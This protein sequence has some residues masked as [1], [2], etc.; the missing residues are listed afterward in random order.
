MNKDLA[1]RYIDIAS[2][3][4]R[5]KYISTGIGQESTYL[6][7]SMQAREY[8]ASGYT[9]TIP[10]FV[11]VEMDVTGMTNIQAT[12][13]ILQTEQQWLYLA[14]TIERIRRSAKIHID[15]LEDQNQISEYCET[16]LTQLKN[17]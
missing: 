3:E 6:I 15:S 10:V 1:K 17:I 2:S 9:G 5:G 13:Y 14:S 8:K 7:K 12:D 16:I 4:A 11:Q